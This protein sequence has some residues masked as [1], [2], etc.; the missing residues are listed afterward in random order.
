MSIASIALFT[1]TEVHFSVWLARFGSASKIAEGHGLFQ[2]IFTQLFLT[3]KL[4]KKL[5]VSSTKMAMGIFQGQRL[6][7]FF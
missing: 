7:P 3:L 6:R 4:R 2:P 5:S 1:L